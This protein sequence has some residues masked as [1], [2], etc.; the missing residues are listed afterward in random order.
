M[1]GTDQSSINTFLF[2]CVITLQYISI[3]LYNNLIIQSNNMFFKAHFGN[4]KA[5]E[6]M[7]YIRYIRCNIPG[8]KELFDECQRVAYDNSTRIYLLRITC[9]LRVIEPAFNYSIRE[10]EVHRPL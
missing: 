8:S 2:V 7:R 4:S 6:G 1:E 3:C 10:A 5:W 9:G